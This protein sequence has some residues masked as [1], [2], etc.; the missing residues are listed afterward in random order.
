[1]FPNDNCRVVSLDKLCSF[2][3]HISHSQHLVAFVIFS[4]HLGDSQEIWGEAATFPPM[5]GFLP[6]VD[7]EA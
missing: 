2:H 7:V 6:V 1:M 4:G 5:S 3:L